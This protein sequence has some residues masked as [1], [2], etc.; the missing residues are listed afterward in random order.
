MFRYI[1]V[2]FSVCL[3]L[4][5]LCF[6]PFGEVYSMLLLNVR[7][8]F[9]HALTKATQDATKSEIRLSHL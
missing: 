4:S 2:K 7:I 8:P 1:R 3:I 9:L 5:F 6:L